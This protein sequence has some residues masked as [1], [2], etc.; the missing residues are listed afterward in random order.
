MP[1]FSAANTVDPFVVNARLL[2][3]VSKLQWLLAV[4]RAKYQQQTAIEWENPA[5]RREITGL[6][7]HP[8]I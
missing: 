5:A 4:L 3:R 1:K 2:E 8:Y 6:D 7:V